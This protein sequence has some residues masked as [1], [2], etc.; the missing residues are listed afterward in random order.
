MSTLRAY[1]ELTAPEDRYPHA[2]VLIG[3]R[4]WAEW[5]E[6]PGD[7][8]VLRITLD[9][10]HG[11]LDEWGNALEYSRDDAAHGTLP[12]FRVLF[13]EHASSV[14]MHARAPQPCALCK[15]PLSADERGNPGDYCDRCLAKDVPTC[16]GCGEYM[17]PDEGLQEAFC[18]DCNE[19][20]DRVLLE[21]ARRVL[22]LAGFPSTLTD[23]GA[24][25]LLW[26]RRFCDRLDAAV[27]VD[28]CN[29]GCLSWTV[30]EH[31]GADPAEAWHT[32]DAVDA[33]AAREVLYA[34]ERIK[35]DE[36]Q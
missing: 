34:L 32:T 13:W 10:H 31:G 26:I 22:E 2:F 12:P 33:R 19:E 3:E 20:H 29:H 9:Q 1:V 4:G 7:S 23:W 14:P 35:G 15:R 27:M 11:G 25:P 36:G 5:P 17:D 21:R 18:E 16:H 30:F 8:I 6:D 28:Q 24:G